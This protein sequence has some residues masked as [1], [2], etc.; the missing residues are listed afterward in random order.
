M[1]TTDLQCARDL[2]ARDPLAAY[3]N[4]FLFPRGKNGQPLNYLCGNSLGLQPVGVHDLVLEEL[5]R[6]ATLG[7]DGHFNGPKPWYSYHENFNKNLS[8]IVGAREH[9]IVIMNT[10]TANLHLLMVSFYRPTPQRFKILIEAGAFPSDQYAV[11]SQARFHGFDP[12]DAILEMTP[13]AGE[14]NLRTEDI[15]KYLAEH[16]QEIALV[17]F[18]GINYYTGQVF[19]MATIAAAAKRQGC[20]VGFDLA[21]AVGNVELSLHDWDV[22]FAVWCTYKYLNAGPGAVAGCFVH[23]RH[24]NNP[25]LPRFAGWW[26]NDPD[27]RF[28]MSPDFVPQT[29]AAGWQL[30]NAPVLAMASL[31][32]S[33]QMFY[34]AKMPNLRQKSL[35]L[36]DYLL[37]LLDQ[38]SGD[39]FEVITPRDDASR[40]CQVSLRTK[41][42][43]KKLFQRLTDAGIVGDF[44][45]PD[46]IRVAPTPLYNSFED[47]WNFWNVLQKQ[48]V[49]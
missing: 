14:D 12:D 29:G 47:V 42:D 37:F 17:M 3:R 5:D 41:A 26:G 6:W 9:E 48:V 46:V 31:H 15:E 40:G 21:H 39:V 28:Q 43:G 36:T 10:L 27:K 13:R 8:H 20:V 30:S 22:D 4:K 24:A 49:S 19:D 45:E 33:L 18:G 34:D 23:E 35:A 1:Y 44:R 38:I 7:V 11:A 32:A 2:D 16:G 25:D